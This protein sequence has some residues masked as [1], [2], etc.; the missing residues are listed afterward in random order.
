MLP[1]IGSI[2]MPADVPHFRPAGSLPQF[3]VTIGAGLG[4]PSPVIGLPTVPESGEHAAS[5]TRIEV[6]RLG[7]RTRGEGMAED[8]GGLLVAVAVAGKISRPR[9]NFT[10][11]RTQLGPPGDCGR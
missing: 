9:A 10:R 4:R 1:S 2:S 7:I 11:V 8:M 6:N 3:W 5:R